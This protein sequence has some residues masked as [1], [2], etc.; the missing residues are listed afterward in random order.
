MDTLSQVFQIWSVFL[1]LFPGF[2]YSVCQYCCLS[3]D[4]F[5]TCQQLYHSA[6]Q[7][8]FPDPVDKG[9][10]DRCS[11]VFCTDRFCPGSVGSLVVTYG[12]C[13]NSVGHLFFPDSWIDH[14]TGSLMVIYVRG[15]G[16][17]RF[18]LSPFLLW[19]A[20]IGSRLDSS[21]LVS[22][23]PADHFHAGV[24]GDSACSPCS[25]YFVD[26]GRRYIL[27]HPPGVLVV[28]PLCRHFFDRY[29]TLS[30]VNSEI[31]LHVFG[32]FRRDFSPYWFYRSVDTVSD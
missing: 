12:L 27:R 13:R 21:F 7:L 29:T 4:R 22:N 20:L 25:H 3:A 19:I 28:H 15:I 9:I 11:V 6:Y 14:R 2:R 18:H 5:R 8:D 32:L 24:S 23:P 30:A 26:F 16:T 31:P 1:G 10:F 17:F